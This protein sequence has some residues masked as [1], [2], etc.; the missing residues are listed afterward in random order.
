[1]DY[2]FVQ[3]V[4]AQIIWSNNIQNVDEGESPLMSSNVDDGTVVFDCKK[5]SK[6]VFIKLKNK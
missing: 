1:M 2:E 3:T 5:S 4:S 6:I